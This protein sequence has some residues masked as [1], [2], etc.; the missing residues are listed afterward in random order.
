[1]E[2]ELAN[3]EAV[4]RLDELRCFSSNPSLDSLQKKIN[5]ENKQRKEQQQQ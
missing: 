3:E 5:Y 2:K 4:R 1:M